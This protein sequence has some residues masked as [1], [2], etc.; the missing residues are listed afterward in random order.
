MLE[1]TQ[2]RISIVLV[3][4]FNPGIFHPAWFEMQG[5]LPRIESEDAKLEIISNDLA[6][7]SIAW[8]RIE[9]VGDRFTAKTNDESKIGPLYDLV[10]GA[11]K[12]LEHTPVTQLGMN[13][14][15]QYAVSSQDDWHAVGHA[16]APKA[17]WSEYVKEPGMKALV[18]KCKR[19]DDRKGSLNVTIQ[20][21]LP[22]LSSLH[23]WRVEF[24]INDH[25]EFNENSNAL[26]CC[27]VISED[28][29]SSQNY[30]LKLASGL[31][32][33]ALKASS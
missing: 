19:N 28:W 12:I 7:F 30:A 4:S 23:P 18:M 9:V 11:L 31:L 1:K 5:L 26:N 14:E 29:E 22:D 27:Q 6:I 20:P 10:T 21:A 15:L 8:L 3:G 33:D 25:V 17:I 13:R 24:A 16:L 2:D 32:T